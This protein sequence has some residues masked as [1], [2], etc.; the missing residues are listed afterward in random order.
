[1]TQITDA[2]GTA[3]QRF[4]YDDLYRLK[5]ANGSYGSISEIVY[6]EAGNRISMI[7]GAKVITY[8]TDTNSN[9]L[10]SYVDPEKE[11]QDKII[12]QEAYREMLYNI[13][14]IAD[15]GNNRFKE[16]EEGRENRGQKTEEKGCEEKEEH[17]EDRQPTYFEVVNDIYAELVNFTIKAKM[18][19]WTFMG[20]LLQFPEVQDVLTRFNDRLALV[21]WYAYFDTEG[22][23][24]VKD[25]VDVFEDIDITEITGTEHDP[26][27]IYDNN[28]NLIYEADSGMSVEYNVDNK[29]IK[30]RDRAG[31]VIVQYFYDAFGARVKKVTQRATTIYVG[32]L[33]EIEN[34]KASKHYFAG[35][36]GLHLVLTGI[37]PGRV[38][39]WVR[40]D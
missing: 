10:L 6:D 13:K 3:S 18:D 17:A 32:S 26:M 12:I 20:K 31:N 29:P 38:S 37:H 30:V 4:S 40:G 7:L 2:V 15:E 14:K 39:H 22:K 25:F 23:K 33:M 35:R 27:F 36:C 28:G 21:G 16:C 19:I 5:S 8:T 24:L 9:R 34:T 1:M 11:E